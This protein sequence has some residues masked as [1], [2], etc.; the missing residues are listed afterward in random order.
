MPKETTGR[1]RVRPFDA[2]NYLG[3]PTRQA[4]YL[5]AALETEDEAYIKQALLTL[6][7]AQ[8]MS[9]TAR[10]AKV[11]RQGLYKSLSAT[12]DPKL[13]TFLSVVQA[14]G[15]QLTVQGTG[16]VGKA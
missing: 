16:A 11:S 15:F 4:A 5:A 10:E 12:S 2:A 8:G 7:R 6:A 13:S 1:E 3:T 9:A 14:L